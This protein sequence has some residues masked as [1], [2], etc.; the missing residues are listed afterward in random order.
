MHG[1]ECKMKMQHLGVYF[2]CFQ[3]YSESYASIK[4]NYTTQMQNFYKNIIWQL[5]NIHFK[6]Q[7]SK[8]HNLLP[9]GALRSHGLQF[10]SVISY[11][12]S[13]C[14]SGSL[15]GFSPLCRPPL[16]ER[17]TFQE[18]EV[19]INSHINLQQQVNVFA[20]SAAL[21]FFVAV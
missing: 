10:P 12:N 15:Y 6:T 8:T 16:S 3:I 18:E 9:S 1:F 13:R 21:F 19:N 11:E 4:A 5:N 2:N 20:R 17:G 7:R 14:C